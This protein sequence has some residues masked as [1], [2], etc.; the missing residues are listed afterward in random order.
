MER[1]L[2]YEEMQGDWNW[3]DET[4]SGPWQLSLPLVMPIEDSEIPF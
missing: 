2:S 4:D 1:E 3:Q